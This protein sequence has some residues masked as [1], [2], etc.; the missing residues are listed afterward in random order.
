M[1]LAILHAACN[2]YNTSVSLN[3][4]VGFASIERRPLFFTLMQETVT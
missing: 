3:E 1:N 4:F 2:C